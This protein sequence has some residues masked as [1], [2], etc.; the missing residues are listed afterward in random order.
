MTV[1]VHENYDKWL[2]VTQVQYFSGVLTTQ[3]VKFLPWL[4]IVA[5]N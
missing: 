4:Q 5:K 2:N 1:L 3:I